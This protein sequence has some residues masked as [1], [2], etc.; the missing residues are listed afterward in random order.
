MVHLYSYMK[1]LE[2]KTDGR[3]SRGMT[4]KAK[5]LDASLSIVAESGA[6]ALT[7]RAVAKRAQVSLASVTYHFPSSDD[8]RRSTFEYA[9]SRIGMQFVGLVNSSLDI[10]SL[11]EICANFTVDLVTDH[12]TDTITVFEMILAAGHDP[13]LSPVTRL[14]N[15]R[16]AK[17]LKPYLRSNGAAKTVSAA[18]QG[19]VLTALAID[20]PNRGIWLRSAVSDLIR[21]YRFPPKSG[22]SLISSRTRK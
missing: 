20:R 14:L 6:N 19:L 9:G 7:H 1:S 11:P 4:R 15:D 17:L 13:Q 12:R 21:R 3:L 10:E 16:L 2:M 8:L 22:H 18:I 5:L